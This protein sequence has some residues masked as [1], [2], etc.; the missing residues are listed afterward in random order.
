MVRSVVRLPEKSCIYKRIGRFSQ[1][2]VICEKH[3]SDV[4]QKIDNSN[5]QQ[6]FLTDYFD[7][8]FFVLSIFLME[9]LFVGIKISPVRS[10]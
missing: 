10:L 2:G 7:S 5:I 3:S 4:F 1:K 9:F 8:L 6:H